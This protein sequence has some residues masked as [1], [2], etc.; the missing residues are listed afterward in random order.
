MTLAANVMHVNGIPMLVTIS[1]NIR[2]ATVEAL[3]NRN[4]PTL[5]K[6][7]KSVAT[8]YKRAGF[9]VTTSLMDGEFEPMRSDL[10]NL[11]IALNKTARDEHVGDIERFIH[12]LKERMW[13]TYNSLPFTNMPP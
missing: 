5:V 1:R 9:R 10:A 13:A 4:L 2:F 8:V 6:G 7:I 11:E 12:T 3:P